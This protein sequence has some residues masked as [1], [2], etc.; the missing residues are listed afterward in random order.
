MRQILLALGFVVLLSIGLVF[1]SNALG[2]DPKAAAMLCGTFLSLLLTY[3][4][5]SYL[6]SIFSYLSKEDKKA[7]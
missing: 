4:F 7:K 6:Y 1:I 2:F 5:F 3:S